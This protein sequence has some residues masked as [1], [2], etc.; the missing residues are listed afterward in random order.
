MRA[1]GEH[2]QNCHLSYL[3]GSLRTSLENACPGLHSVPALLVYLATVQVNDMDWFS[4]DILDFILQV[5]YPRK[6]FSPRQTMT[7][8]GLTTPDTLYFRFL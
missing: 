6:L 2:W 1:E 7:H 5:P 3:L 4:Q 8:N